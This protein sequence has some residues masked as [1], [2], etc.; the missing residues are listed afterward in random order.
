MNVGFNPARFTP[1]KMAFQGK[2]KT[3]EEL[4]NLKKGQE[5][6]IGTWRVDGD[7][8]DEGIKRDSGTINKVSSVNFYLPNVNVEKIW[9]IE[10]NEKGPNGENGSK[11]DVNLF[12][13]EKG[14]LWSPSGDY[15]ETKD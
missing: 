9:T 3:A 1:N 11:S 7:N 8:G 15:V 4:K 12:E 5:V 14:I 10:I 13:K 6:T 2:I